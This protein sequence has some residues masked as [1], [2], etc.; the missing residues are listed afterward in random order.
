MTDE[1]NIE[2]LEQEFHEDSHGLAVLRNIR[3][4][5]LTI[6]QLENEIKQQQEEMNNVFD[7]TLEH[8]RFH[9]TLRPIV[10]NYCQ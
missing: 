4:I 10:C 3:G 9:M 8:I 7:C 2:E 6:E 5:S 1:R